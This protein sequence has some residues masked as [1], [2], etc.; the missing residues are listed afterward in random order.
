MLGKLGKIIRVILIGIAVIAAVVVAAIFESEDGVQYTTTP[1]TPDWAA[2]AAWPGID[3]A[4]VDARPDPG[5]TF[6]AIILDDSGSMGTD[7]VPARAAV[8]SA[9]GAMDPDDR[10]AVIALNAGTILPFA[11]VARARAELPPLL[12]RVIS[13]GGTPLTGAMVAARDALAQEA[14]V[15]G[16]FGTYRILVTTD[17]AADDGAALQ[18]TVEDIARTTPIQIVTIGVG[19]R[20]NHILRRDDLAAFVAIDDVGQLAGALRDAIAEEQTFSAITSFGG[21]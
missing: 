13:E 14:A 17:G 4:D 16:G 20:G 11:G 7:I 15:A 2:I 6:T 19:I 3:A 9:L 18:A 8:V 12:E 21:G 10:V 5:R 1:V